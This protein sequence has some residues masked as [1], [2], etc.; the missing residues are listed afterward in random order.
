MDPDFWTSLDE[1][2]RSHALVI[3]RKK[4]SRHPSYPEVIYPLDYG[5]LEGTTSMDG[6]GIDVWLGSQEELNINGIFCTIDTKKNDAEIKIVIG[7]SQE[8][9]SLIY[10]LHNGFSQAAI[11]V[12]RP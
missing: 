9:I 11:W 4:G 10:N 5:Y 8:E 1:L 3:D 7:C 6:N 12:S 2:R